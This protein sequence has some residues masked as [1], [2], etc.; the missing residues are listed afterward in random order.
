[1]KRIIYLT[2]LLSVICMVAINANLPIYARGEGVNSETIGLLVSLNPLMS[3]IFSFPFSY[4]SD[5]YNRFIV[6]FI[7]V[8]LYFLASLIL[9]CFTSVEALF[10]VKILEGLALAAYLPAVI[11]FRTDIGH[12]SNLA[13]NIGSFAAVFNAGFVIAP[14]FSGIIGQYYGIKCIFWFVFLCSVLNM[15][16]CIPLYR[17]YKQEQKTQEVQIKK[18]EDKENLPKTSFKWVVV[19]AI[20]GFSFAIG[21]ALGL[22]DSV[23]AYFMIDKGGNVFTVNLSYLAYAIPVAILSKI[24]GTYADRYKNLV[25][26][27]LI[28]SLSISI[29]IAIYAF[30][31]NALIIALL[32]SI[33]GVGFAIV[34][35]GANSAIIKSVDDSYKGRA[36]GIFNTARTAGSFLGAII[37][38][39]IF[40]FSHVVPFLINSSFI[41]LTGFIAAYAIYKYKI[42]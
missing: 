21:Y 26:P 11:A 40:S 3:L 13:E 32:C 35:P 20:S 33:E 9:A 1:M 27:M 39:Y 19:I 24:M 14:A 15:L 18:Q 36:L 34:Y 6:I 7:G 23:W 5:K 25:L 16:V 28:G 2:I 17:L 10:V 29:M 38:G 12:K 42:H 31:P 22:Y 8:F 41:L 4:I 37:T 30:L